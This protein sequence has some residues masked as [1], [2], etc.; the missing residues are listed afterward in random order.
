MQGAAGQQ[1]ITKSGCVSAHLVPLRLGV[2][3]VQA[4]NALDVQHVIQHKQHHIQQQ[5]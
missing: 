1:Q 3:E 4:L 2:I 5:Q